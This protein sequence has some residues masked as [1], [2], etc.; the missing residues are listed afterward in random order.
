MCTLIW[1]I[2]VRVGIN[3]NRLIPEPTLPGFHFKNLLE[4]A[5]DSGTL[6]PEQ[7]CSSACNL[8]I[9]ILEKDRTTRNFSNADRIRV[10]TAELH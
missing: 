5:G 3:D 6:E 2:V 9:R 7:T 8:E 1:K 4:D 10:L